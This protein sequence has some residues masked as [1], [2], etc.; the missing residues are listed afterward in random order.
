M[1]AG[2]VAKQLLDVR[3]MVAS[4]NAGPA[5]DLDIGSGLWIM[6]AAAAV[7][8]VASFRLDTPAEIV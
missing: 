8:L 7:G 4:L 1:V 3:D 2:L 6:L 5:A